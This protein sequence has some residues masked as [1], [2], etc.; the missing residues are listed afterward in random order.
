METM[1]ADARREIIAYAQLMRR[2]ILNTRTPSGNSQVLADVF[3][4]A[5]T[6][7]ANFTW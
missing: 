6:F 2:N 1:Q 3:F 7:T 5:F 4:N